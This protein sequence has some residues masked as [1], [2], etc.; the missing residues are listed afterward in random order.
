MDAAFALK[1][2]KAAGSDSILNNDILQLL[3]TRRSG[4]NWKN[5]EILTFLHKM[6]RHLWTEEKVPEKF[7]EIVLRPFIKDA[8][9]DP[10]KPSNY[11]PVAL[12]NVLMK[13][14]EHII[15]VRLET[16]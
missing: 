13:V 9:K 7:K 15:N 3:D 12:L 1:S 11:R 14:Y 5:V 2:N 8:D 6:M 4:E 16:Y 10:T